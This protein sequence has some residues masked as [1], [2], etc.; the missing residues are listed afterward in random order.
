MALRIRNV[1][2]MTTDPARLADFWQG[3]L[4]LP[5]RRDG[6]HEVLLADADWSYPRL[7]FQ[8]IDG[9]KPK[10]GPLHLDLLAEDR[11]AEVERLVALGATEGRT[12]ADDPSG[13]V[14]TVLVDPDGNEL[15][16]TE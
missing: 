13:V 2:F 15:C 12:V 9:T 6:G 3:A 8:L 1:T 4:A 5:E 14:W 16:V 10:P 7:T 11:A